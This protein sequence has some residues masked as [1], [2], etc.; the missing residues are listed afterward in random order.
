MNRHFR[1]CHYFSV[2]LQLNGALQLIEHQSSKVQLLKNLR[3]TECITNL[4][5]QYQYWYLVWNGGILFGMKLSWS[6]TAN[7]EFQV[8][9]KSPV[10]LQLNVA[11]TYQV[12]YSNSFELI[13]VTL[14]WLS[15]SAPSLSDPRCQPFWAKIIRPLPRTRFISV[16]FLKLSAPSFQMLI[17]PK[18]HC[19]AVWVALK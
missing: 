19:V 13:Y 11:S 15:S 1:K 6:M 2:V 9:L 12:Q 18:Y 16:F 3:C 10:M 17:R 7:W 8:C 14:W 4:S 5:V